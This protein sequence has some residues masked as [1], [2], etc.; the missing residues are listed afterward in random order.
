MRFVI[1][2]LISALLLISCEHSSPISVPQSDPSPPLALAPP[3]PEEIR[4][5]KIQA[6]ENEIADIKRQISTLEKRLEKAKLELATVDGPINLNSAS[7]D[8]LMQLPRCGEKTAI[9]IIKYRPIEALEDLLMIPG[10]GQ[11]TLD[12]WEPFVTC[13]GN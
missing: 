12:L 6:L 1:L 9:A 8:V 11:K 2:F 7:K 3:S 5:A 4:Q 13:E 10:I